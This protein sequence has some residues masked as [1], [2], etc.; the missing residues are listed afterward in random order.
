MHKRLSALLINPYIYD[1]SAYGFWSAPLGLLYMGAIL[2][3][4]GLRVSLLDCLVEQEEKR[5]EDGRA[6][7]VKE[8]V[9]NPGATKGLPKNFRRYGMS[10][11]EVSR[12]L[13]TMEKPDF[14]LI[15]CCMTYWYTGAAEIVRLARLAFPTALIAVGG[16]YP[17]LCPDHADREMPD[18]DIIV[19][20]DNLG[21]FYR[22]IEEAQGD[23]LSVSPGRDCIAEF[24][25]PAFDLY[26]RRVYVPLLTSVG[27]I[28]NCTY[29]ATSYLRS[30]IVRRPPRDVLREIVYWNGKDISR[31]A[32]YDDG[33]L[34]DPDGFAKPLLMGIARLPFD[35]SIYNPNAM[36]AALIDKEVAALL[37][38]AR[39]QEVRLGLETSDSDI[40]R[41]TGGKINK[42]TFEKAVDHLLSAGFSRHVVQAYVMAGLPEQR[43]ENV[44]ESVDFA[45]GLGIT[46]TLAEYTPI[47][48]SPMFERYAR[49]ARYPIA[50]EPLFQNNAL[51]PFA[52]EGFTDND[53]VS[54]KTYV[55]G[56][57]PV[58]KSVPADDGRTAGLLS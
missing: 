32:L 17:A 35:V 31:F 44:K 1:V 38:G 8:R 27:C 57:N 19:G 12:R 52:W 33:F 50:E 46:V 13:A 47:P 45:I 30:A 39:F 54:L 6:P 5:K 26:K 22:M 7:F 21:A 58:A 9:E 24:P 4:A 34:V 41:T 23:R 16:V 48:H 28:Y 51:F 37:R 11:N 42:R 53:L 56:K 49:L 20:R 40:Q 55:R 2:R 10:P 15:T 14:I 43:W 25:Y 36:N 18:A 3:K 29:C